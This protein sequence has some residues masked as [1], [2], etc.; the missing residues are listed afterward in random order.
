[1]PLTNFSSTRSRG[2]CLSPF[3]CGLVVV[4]IIICVIL[5][6][7]PNSPF[8]PHSSGHPAVHPTPVRHPT[9]KHIT[10]KKGHLPVQRE[11]VVPVFAPMLDGNDPA[12]SSTAIEQAAACWQRGEV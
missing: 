7:Y 8:R 2:G 1:M 3:G 9:P 5:T 11:H 4:G 12:G 6:I 10:P